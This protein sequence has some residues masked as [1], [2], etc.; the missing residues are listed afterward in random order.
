MAEERQLRVGFIGAGE[1][2]VQTAKAVAEAP[3][4]RLVAVTDA[5]PELAR[6][7]AQR[8][9]A[10]AVATPDELL[11]RS[12]VEAVYIA[13]PH[14]LHALLAQAAARAGKHILLEKPTGT[15]AEE[16]ER[17][18]RTAQECGVTLSVPFIYRYT[19][20]W[21]ALRSL[22]ADG[23]LGDL[24]AVRIVYLA[25]KPDSYWQGGY[26]GRSPSD[27]RTRLLQAG[28][29]VLIMNCVHDI[30][31]VRWAT[32]LEA[33]RVFAEYGTFA[34]PGVEVEDMLVAVIQYR[35][36]AV[37]VIEAGSHVP[38]G[39]GPRGH[40]G[41]RFI[42]TRGQAVLDG[43]KL[44]VYTEQGDGAEVAGTR[45]QPG[46]WQEVPLQPEG[47]PRTLLVEDWARALL[48]GD[49][50]PIPE[51]AGFEAMRIISAAYQSRRAGRAIRIEEVLQKVV[52][53]PR[54]H[55]G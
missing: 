8:Y 29:G 23:V 27:W 30:D 52:M 40:G 45:L 37:G 12:D 20:A 4:A 54:K 49:P 21:R 24:Q 48:A 33:E 55:V 39:A 3:H 50:P 6:D 15:S 42:G 1:I 2:A 16:S 5:R 35:G 32:G 9:G 19:P 26:T 28:G 17:A 47:E 44:W 53:A 7:L 31:A 11:E 46:Q 38:G 34:T 22:V 43:G 10:E 25:R 18:L 36:G 14:F 41:H 51:D 13:V